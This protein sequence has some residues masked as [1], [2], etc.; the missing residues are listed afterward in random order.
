MV[1]QSRQAKASG[2]FFRIIGVAAL[3]IVVWLVYLVLS[4]RIA[5]GK[6]V[7]AICQRP[8]HPA[9]VFL[10]ISQKEGERRACCPRCGLRFVIESNGKPSQ[11]TDLSSG[12]LIDAETAIYLEGSD[13]MQ[14]C[15]STTM[16]TDSGM[17]CEMHYDRC[18]PSLVAFANLQSARTYQQEHGGRLIDLAE[19]RTRVARQMG[20]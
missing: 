18:M 8:L 4:G 1:G 3:G 7:C 5:Q 6:Q 16:R 11:A 17:I 13:L 9:Q 12:Q 2:T 10:V 14:C 15:A 20:K 19:A